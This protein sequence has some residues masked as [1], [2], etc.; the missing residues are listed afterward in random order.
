M[1]RRFFACWLVAL[2]LTPFTAPFAT[3]DLSQVLSHDKHDGMPAE[4]EAP[5]GK[6]AE[7]AKSVA[8]DFVSPAITSILLPFE[9][10]PAYAVEPL[11][12]TPCP[13]ALRACHDTVL[14]L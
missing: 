4:P 1:F 5:F 14:R 12:P 2:A 6:G 11:H 3:C 9:L 10:V 13:D 8:D 7:K